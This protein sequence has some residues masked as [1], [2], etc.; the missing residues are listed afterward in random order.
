MS[1]RRAR[2]RLGLLLAF[3]LLQVLD[4]RPRVLTALVDAL[5][6]AANAPKG[7][8][9]SNSVAAAAGIV[10][11]HRWR[12]HARLGDTG[13]STGTVASA[14][15][16]SW[17]SFVRSWR[18]R[19]LRARVAPAMAPQSAPSGGH[20]GVTVVVPVP[21]GGGGSKHRQ[22]ALPQHASQHKVQGR[23]LAAG[24]QQQQPKGGRGALVNPIGLRASTF[25]DFWVY[26][27]VNGTAL[28]EF[29]AQRTSTYRDI[30]AAT[31]L[32]SNHMASLTTVACE[33]GTVTQYVHKVRWSTTC[34]FCRA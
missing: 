27:G 28:Q 6:A 34:D 23:E 29:A 2:R 21:L 32:F 17:R 30:V 18:V 16:A 14:L 13:A 19:P 25:A 9:G 20:N 8:R 7:W 12:R 31:R 33:Q 22:G 10:P 15:S 4:S 24:K 26:I 5:C 1:R 11:N 3:Q